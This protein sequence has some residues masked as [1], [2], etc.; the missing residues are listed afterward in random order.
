VPELPDVEVFRRRVARNALHRPIERVRVSDDLVVR[1][2]S[3]QTLR[4]RLRGATLTATRRHGK[5][6]FV[7]TDADVHLLLHFGMTGYVDPLGPE[8]PEPGHQR[9]RFDFRDGGRLAFVDQRRLGTVGLVDDVDAW[10]E[11]HELGPDALSVDRSTLR[12]LLR[13]WRGALVGMLMSQE[14]IAGVGNIYSDE[15]LFQAR[16]EPR[17]RTDDLT[18]TEV[19]RL[20]RQLGRVLGRAIEADAQPERMPR[21]W[22][23]QDRRAGAECPRG[24]GVVRKYRAGGRTGYW[25]PTCQ[26]DGLS[27]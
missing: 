15:V 9:V 1:G 6:L 12:R 17:R 8:D 25:C 4:R 13:E 27:P 21:G 5:H 7:A 2:T 14:T 23:I 19:G 11:E 18:A 24:R 10:V 20:H 26:D 22:L 16:L 3:P